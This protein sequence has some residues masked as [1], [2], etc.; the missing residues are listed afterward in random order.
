MCPVGTFNPDTHLCAINNPYCPT[1][2][3]PTTTTELTDPST[4]STTTE[5]TRPSTTIEFTNPPITS[6]LS[7]LQTGIYV[8]TG[9]I[10]SACLF[11]A[12]GIITLFI[13][14]NKLGF[15]SFIVPM[16]YSETKRYL[17]LNQGRLQD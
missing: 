11:L 13:S 9:V 4:T 3:A 2:E 6:A 14:L 7:A 5:L 1:T 10:G 15:H 8:F 12:V 17:F 16:S